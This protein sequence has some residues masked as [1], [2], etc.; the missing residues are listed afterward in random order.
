[1]TGVKSAQD[2]LKTNDKSPLNSEETGG[3][4]NVNIKMI[5]FE[6]IKNNSIESS[7]VVRKFSDNYS[8]LKTLS[9]R[10]SSSL[11][12]SIKEQSKKNEEESAN[13]K[14]DIDSMIKIDYVKS[15]SVSL[16]FKLLLIV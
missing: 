9:E 8:N 7:E 1:M 10:R 6:S 14:I 13:K 16:Y 11:S 5:K 15:F 12:R 2:F 3:S 4:E